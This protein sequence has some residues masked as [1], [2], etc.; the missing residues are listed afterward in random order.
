MTISVIMTTYNAEKY[1]EEAIQSVLKQTF[2]DFEFIIVDDGSTDDTKSILRRIKDKRIK[3]WE[4]EHDFIGSLNWALSQVTGKYIA[5]MDADDIMHP[6]RLRIQYALMEAEPS[7]DICGTW[8]KPFSDKTPKTGALSSYHGDKE[9]LILDLLKGNAFFHPTM[10]FRTNFFRTNSLHYENYPFAEDYK[11]WFE[12]A[13]CGARFYVE[14]QSLHYYRISEDQVSVRKNKEQYSSTIAIRKE[15]AEY[16]INKAEEKDIILS[17][18]NLMLQMEEKELITASLLWISL[19]E[20][21][22]KAQ[23]ANKKE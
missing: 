23:P 16:L 17:Y 5:R 7:I 14:P 12:A 22:K 6:E 10:M 11:L 1:V 9:L 2:K 13:K 19:Y 20:V 15:I 8:M 21:L 3:I 18:Y 4:K